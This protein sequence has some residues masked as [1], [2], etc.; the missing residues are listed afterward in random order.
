[1]GLGGP[2]VGGICCLGIRCCS[3]PRKSRN[4]CSG[5]CAGALF[6]RSTAST[7]P[8][9]TRRVNSFLLSLSLPN[10]KIASTEAK[11]V[12]PDQIFRSYR[13]SLGSTFVG[14]VCRSPDLPRRA[15]EK[16]GP[17]HSKA[18]GGRFN[19]P[20]EGSYRYY[21][22][23]ARLRPALPAHQGSSPAVRR[24][25]AARDQARRLSRHRAQGPRRSASHVSRVRR[26][27]RLP[28]NP[29]QRD[30]SPRNDRE[31]HY[32]TGPPRRERI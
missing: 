19:R 4:N 27:L 23:A 2:I 10:K 8:A 11:C 24:A 17:P 30:Q 26:C 18:H 32:R 14:G 9:K 31:A 22:P 13:R 12:E 20:Y 6:I 5:A 15:G 25:M 21:A 16:E 28:S 29:R 3:V 1:M 7:P